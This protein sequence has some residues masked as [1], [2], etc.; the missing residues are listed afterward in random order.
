MHKEVLTRAVENAE[1]P[2]EV[3][4][5]IMRDPET[6]PNMRFEAAKAAAPYVH[7]RLSQVDSTVTH[8]HDVDELSAS[9][10][11]QLLAAELAAREKGKADSKRGTDPIH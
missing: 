9:E 5:G 11:D 1:T 6:E 8:K 3:M 4:L 7:P 2:L 10:L